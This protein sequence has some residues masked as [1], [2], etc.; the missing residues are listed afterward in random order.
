MKF[1]DAYRLAYIKTHFK[2]HAGFLLEVYNVQ[3]SE[4]AY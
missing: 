2:N 1:T 4:W 3:N